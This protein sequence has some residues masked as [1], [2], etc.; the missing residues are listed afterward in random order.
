M[1]LRTRAASAAL[2]VASALSS[3]LDTGFGNWIARAD[4][5]RRRLKSSNRFPL[6][7]VGSDG[8]IMAGRHAVSLLL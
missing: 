1:T 8:G 3:L 7:S 5:V 6:Q 2:S 4:V